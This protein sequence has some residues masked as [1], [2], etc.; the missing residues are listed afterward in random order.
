MLFEEKGFRIEDEILVHDRGKQ[1]IICRA[2]HGQE[3]YEDHEYLY[4]KRLIEKKD[5]EYRKMLVK[6]AEGLSQWMSR[7]QS[8]EQKCR[9]EKERERILDILRSW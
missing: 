7:T 5:P 2:V 4:G 9:M 1:Y 6:K 3:Y 8:E